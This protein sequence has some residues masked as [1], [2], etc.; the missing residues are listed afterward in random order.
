M[1]GFSLRI[2]AS[3][4]IQSREKGALTEDANRLIKTIKQMETSLEDKA[5]SSSY[6]L[7]RDDLKVTLPLMHCLESLKIKH[8]S[9]AKVHR[10]RLEQV[11]SM[12]VLSRS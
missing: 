4:L 1:S 6:E 10:E 12:L 11:Q 7:E 8:N 5:T 2:S 3:V 9:I